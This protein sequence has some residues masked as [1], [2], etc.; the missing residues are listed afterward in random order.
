MT[1]PRCLITGSAH[2][3]GAALK[4]AFSKD[5]DIIEYDLQ[6]DQDLTLESVRDSVIEDLKTCAIFFNNAQPYQLELLDRAFELQNDLAIVNSSSTVKQFELPENVK[7]DP[8]FLAYA[9]EKTAFNKRIH[10]IHQLQR[11]GINPRAWVINVR[12]EWLDV[13][14]HHGRPDPLT[15]PGDVAGY[16]Y[17]LLGCWPRIVVDDILIRSARPFNDG[18]N[19]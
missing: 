16:L 1:R 9:E 11:K 15:D 8:R 2:G 19:A 5:F 14:L 4:H 18:S 7:D 13:P 6:Y 17:H 10:E 12:L 3:L